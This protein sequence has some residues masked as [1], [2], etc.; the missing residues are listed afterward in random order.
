MDWYEDDVKDVIDRRDACSY[1]P[2]TIFYGSSTIRLWDSLYEDF[3]DYKPVNLGF[4]GSTLAACIWFFDRILTPLKK[5]DKIIM[6]AGD[7]D[8]GD[9]RHPEEVCI[10][11]RQFILKLREHFKDIK[12]YFIS[13][14]PSISRIDI[15][16]QIIYT[17]RLIENEI[18]T[19]GNNEYYVNV[20]DKM[21][22]KKGK[23]VRS[24]FDADGLHLDK[25]GYE[26]WKETILNECLL[27][28]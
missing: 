17:N 28:N 6:Y 1:E 12:C 3:K 18:K 27:K 8:L 7:N 22:N 24:F 25:K 13:V 23:P 9:G 16:E 20:Y 4:G 26:V 14:K 19:K 21:I 11:Y 10:F 5:A 2:A 15:L